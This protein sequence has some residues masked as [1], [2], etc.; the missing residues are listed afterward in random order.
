MKHY[1]LSFVLLFAMGAIY[2]E[3]GTLTVISVESARVTGITVITYDLTTQSP[4]KFNETYNISVEVSFDGGGTYTAVLSAYLSGDVED[5]APGTGRQI[6][7]D[8]GAGFPNTY[9]TDA[10]VRL[11]ATNSF[12]CGESTVT[13][14]YNG[15]LVTYGTVLVDYGGTIGERCWLDRNL[16]ADP[17]PFVPAD[18]ATGNTDTRL[19]GDLFQWG[20][21]DDGHQDRD[22]DNHDGQADGLASTFE[23]NT[24][25]DWDGKFI[26]VNESPWDW[27]EDQN[28]DLWQGV[29]G[30][31]NPCP[32]G[33]RVPTEA[34]LN[35][36]R[37]SW[38]SNN[39]AGAYASTLKWPVA[40]FRSLINGSLLNVGSLGVYWSSTVD[41]IYSRYLYFYSGEAYML[42]D[43]RA[44]G[45][46]VRCLK[47]H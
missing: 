20:R 26:T 32:P 4:V 1:I 40:G 15:S 36:E 13:F 2:A 37:E 45:L 7:W 29:D 8:G 41:G 38:S 43:Y 18:D 6:T 42:Y 46:S 5:V 22:S 14:M 3:S 39:S 30:A 25:E 24:G 12:I 44:L 23:P 16:G 17:M 10:K 31:N 19:Y 11:T 34:E 28:V 9:S 27:L 21:G 47:D 35:A 33:W